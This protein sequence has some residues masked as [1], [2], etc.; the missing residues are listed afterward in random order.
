MLTTDKEEHE[1]VGDEVTAN[2][3]IVCPMCVR[4]INRPIKP[5]NILVAAVP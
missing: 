4:R 2:I 1:P 5:I 3:P